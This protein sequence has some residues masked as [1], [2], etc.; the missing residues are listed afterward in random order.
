MQ[1][2]ARTPVTATETN[3]NKETPSESSSKTLSNTRRIDS[4]DEMAKSTDGN[5]ENIHIQSTGATTTTNSSQ[6]D[7]EN[8]TN[9]QNTNLFLSES[10]D[11]CVLSVISCALASMKIGEE[12]VSY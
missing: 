9:I 4:I 2:G 10:D 1:N 5:T 6:D 12:T 3:L 11:N 7:N 8:L